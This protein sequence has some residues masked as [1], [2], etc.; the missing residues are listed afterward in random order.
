MSR[1]RKTQS[2][3]AVSDVEQKTS[4]ICGNLQ[5]RIARELIKKGGEVYSCC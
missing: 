5:D 1:F 3:N 2:E 4:D